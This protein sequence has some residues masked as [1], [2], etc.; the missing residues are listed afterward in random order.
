MKIKEIYGTVNPQMYKLV[1]DD[2]VTNGISTVIICRSWLP[3]SQV[4]QTT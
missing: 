4:C 2:F 3:H 1:N